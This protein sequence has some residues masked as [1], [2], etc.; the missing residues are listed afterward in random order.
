MVESGLG[1]RQDAVNAGLHAERDGRRQ[2]GSGGGN[3]RR[4][5]DEEMGRT[6]RALQA[7]VKGGQENTLS[8]IDQE[9]AMLKCG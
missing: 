3:T 4:A 5:A 1:Q 6:W 7:V 9:R 8:T 2:D